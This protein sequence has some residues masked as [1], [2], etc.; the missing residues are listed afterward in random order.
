[1]KA[2]DFWKQVALDRADLLVKVIET[3]R[4]AGVRF[5]AVG[6]FA[7]NAY[8]E[9]APSRLSNARA[10]SGARFDSSGRESRLV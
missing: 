9:P 1:M 3:L 6:D 5:C 2:F 8:A 4:S 10:T 7:V